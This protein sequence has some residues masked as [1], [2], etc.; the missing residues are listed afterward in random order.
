MDEIIK[1]V[2]FVEQWGIYRLCGMMGEVRRACEKKRRTEGF[3]RIKYRWDSILMC[4]G[5]LSAGLGKR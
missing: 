4:R 1:D 2:E 5:G 3:Y